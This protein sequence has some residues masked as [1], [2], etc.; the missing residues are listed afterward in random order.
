V[1]AEDYARAREVIADTFVF[2]QQAV[3]EFFRATDT[4]PPTRQFITELIENG[5]ALFLA[6]DGEVV[7]GFLTIRV[8]QAPDELYL[9]PVC[10]AIIDNL[11]IKTDRRRQGIGQ[12][13][14][15]AAQEWA[16]QQRAS[17]VQLTVWEFNVGAIAFYESLGYETLSRSMWKSL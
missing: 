2:H 13:L 15:E 9:A 1:G 6:Q 11:G 10:E 5:G 17:R 3:P 12:K 8:R 7:V 16:R 4:P 14:M